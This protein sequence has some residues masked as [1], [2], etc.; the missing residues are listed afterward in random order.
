MIENHSHID[1]SAIV[2]PWVE[3]GHSCI[4]GEFCVIGRRATPTIAMVRDLPEDFG[5]TCI[6]PRC[7][8]SA[9]AV[10]YTRVSIG[11][12][13]LF[14]D[15]ASVFYDVNIGDRVLLSRNVTI[16]SSVEIGDDTRIMDNT[17]ITGRSKIGRAVFFSVGV[18]SVN[19]NN[20]G[21][22]GFSDA[23]T[24]TTI[25]DFASIGPGVVLMPGCIVGP[26]SII[27]GSSVVKGYIPENVIAAGNPAKV[28]CRVP[29]HLSRMV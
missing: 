10:I 14:G 13:C 5:K 21:K 12:D 9:G 16:N 1:E 11:S 8:F 26:G 17:H 27:A 23:V 22:Q 24:G 25:G 3:L 15:H 6:G 18:T 4:V 19:D 29:K 2:R 7:S 28:I 20:F